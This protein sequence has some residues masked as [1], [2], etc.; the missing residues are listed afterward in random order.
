M[1]PMMKK[2]LDVDQVHTQ[3]PSRKLSR[4]DGVAIFIIMASTTGNS[5]RMEMGE[6]RSM[7]RPFQ[8][9]QCQNLKARTDSTS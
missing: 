5:K 2:L 1:A 4:D 6:V 7:C 9:K 8:C 3:D